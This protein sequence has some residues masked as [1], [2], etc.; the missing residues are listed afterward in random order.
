MKLSIFVKNLN[1]RLKNRHSYKHQSI[2]RVLIFG[3]LIFYLL[4]S[5][6]CRTT[7]YVED[8]EYLLSNNEIRGDI[9]HIDKEELETYI[10]QK[11][12]KKILYFSK[13]HLGLYNL[14]KKEKETGISGWLKTIGEAPV[15]YDPFLKD[16]SANQF[17]LYLRSKGY[18]N[19]QVIDTVEFKKKKAKVIYHIEPGIPYKIRKVKYEFE[20]KN[21]TDF[22]LDDT[23]NSF[24]KKDE[25]LDVD[26]MDAERG[27]IEEKLKEQ[28]FYSFKKE[29]IFFMV[30]SSL[31]KHQ[32]DV[33]IVFKKYSEYK[34]E[35]YTVE[36]P[37]PQYVIGKI[38]LNT[39]YQLRMALANDEKYLSSLDTVK[40]KD[41]SVVYMAEP[42][43]KPAVVVESSY[44]LP[45]E[46]FD[47]RNVKRTYRNLS[48]L[49]LFRLT[50]IEFKENEAYEDSAFRV[51]D[52]EIFLTP[53][54]LQSL[55]LEPEITNSSGNIGAAGNL[56]YQHRNLF[57]G[58]ENLDLRLKGAMET[59][60][61]SNIAGYGNMLELG[62]ELR[63]SIPKFLLPFKTDQFIKKF[64]PSTS[65]SF[66]YNY[67]RRPDYARTIANASFGYTW[68][69]NKYLTHIVNPIELNLIK[70]PY[71]SQDFTDWLEGKYIYYSYQPHLVTVTNY[72]FIYSNQNIQKKTDFMYFKMNFES[73]G[74]ILYSIYK[75]GN[76][77]PVDGNYRLFN[78]E[79]AQYVR[80]DFDFRYYNVIDESNTLVYR[81]FAGAGLPYKNSTA[82]PFEKKYFAGGAN[83]IRAW[84]VRNLGPGSYEEVEASAYPNKTADIKL[85]ANLEYRFK[86]F[87][88]LEG[89]LFVDAGNIW[90]INKADERAG[91]LFE[92]NSFYKDIAVGTG[93][94]T[95]FD[96]SYFVF[97]FDLGIKTR[98]PIYPVG[99]KWIF[100]NRKL[101]RKD[102]V[103][104]VG[105]GYPF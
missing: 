101:E 19:A 17:E 40:Y 3:L 95:R 11:P 77:A 81:F 53:Q 89:A 8:G 32:V 100:G 64:N 5:Y 41:V 57:K 88:L 16:K 13:F 63:L 27:R 61:E 99:E 35:G 6:S 20:D 93:F 79:F 23:V 39:N 82:L 69:G 76:V 30:D 80:S 103:L 26:I 46:L 104:N 74:N 102:F 98:D 2:S 9:K 38:F 44:L 34:D 42:N 12:N 90:A 86:L 49:R 14:S 37:H 1:F 94:G 7:R 33:N 91:A 21:L 72:S 68:K 51:L 70:I 84:Q 4:V 75:W 58:A 52:C 105:I 87:W 31:R 83:S 67:Q 22:I 25:L 97:R 15:I 62:T 60:K 47:I 18:Y 73:A 56:I 85:E 71:Q 43:I 92:L 65:I 59:L 55:T 78:T 24:I 36:I 45:G 28:G 50:S 48:S 54:T 66:A 29:F 96:F 10:K